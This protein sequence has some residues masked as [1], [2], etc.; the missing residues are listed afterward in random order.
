MIFIAVGPPEHLHRT[1]L[2]RRNIKLVNFL[3]L[4]P[5]LMQEGLL[6]DDDYQD[7]TQRHGVSAQQ[8]F[9]IFVTAYF[10][11]QR[12]CNIVQKFIAALRKEKDHPGHKELLT[13]IEADERIMKAVK[14]TKGDY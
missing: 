4:A 5:Y 10:F 11:Q 14:T 1:L 8:H 12:K 2:I 3:Q 6:A 9:K 7:I 13:R